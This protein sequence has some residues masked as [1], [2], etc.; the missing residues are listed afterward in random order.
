MLAKSFYVCSMEEV[1]E[2]EGEREDD[3]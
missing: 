1:E 2:E 3:E